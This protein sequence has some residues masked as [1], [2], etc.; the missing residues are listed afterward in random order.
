MEHPYGFPENWLALLRFA[1]ERVNP[2]TTLMYDMNFADDLVAL[3]GQM[4]PGGELALW[5][6][7]I[8]YSQPLTEVEVAAK[9]ALT[10]FWTTLDAI[11]ID[12][13]RSLARP[14]EILP[15][16]YE[17]LVRMLSARTDNLVGELEQTVADLDGATGKTAALVMKEI[18]FKSVDRGFVDPFLY[19]GSGTFNEM[20]Q[21]AAYEA[22]FRSFS[23]RPLSWF[24]GIVFWDASVDLNLHGP[25]DRG[26]SPLGKMMSEDVVRRFWGQR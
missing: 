18:G 22:V 20:H 26:F 2:T 15:T 6:Q 24:A 23:S 10:E 11:G 16:D 8:A 21:A 4:V 17:G 7:R 12:M 9:T 19:A 13:Y 3:G 1:R 25:F 14:D 5:R